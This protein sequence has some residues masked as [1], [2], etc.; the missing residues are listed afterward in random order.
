MHV[1][2]QQ[3]LQSVA[4]NETTTDRQVP[5]FTGAA[6]DDVHAGSVAEMHERSAQYRERMELVFLLVYVFV[7]LAAIAILATADWMSPFT[8]LREVL[9]ATGEGGARENAAP[10]VMAPARGR[11]PGEILLEPPMLV[12]LLKRLALASMLFSLA[13]YANRH[14][15][16]CRAEAHSSRREIADIAW[17]RAVEMR[18]I[19][20]GQEGRTEAVALLLDG[21]ARTRPLLCSVP[22]DALPPKVPAVRKKRTTS[23]KSTPS[24]A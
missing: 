9:P 18:A 4:R 17:F 14:A 21:A 1:A 10:P 12:A 23:V 8:Q 11:R 6:E 16:A 3:K 22:V 5:V 7:L 2:I 20:F 19:A 24:K 13:F 15:V